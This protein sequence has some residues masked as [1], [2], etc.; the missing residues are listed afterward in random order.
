MQPQMSNL[1]ST[2]LYITG[3]CPL[4][5]D[6]SV[7]SVIQYNIN[8]SGDMSALIRCTTQDDNETDV[9]ECGMNGQWNTD[10]EDVCRSIHTT[11]AHKG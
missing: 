1:N 7:L 8:I 3:R 11:Q 10:I 9:I 2:S 4:L 6:S 5:R